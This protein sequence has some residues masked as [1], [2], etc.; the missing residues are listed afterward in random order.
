MASRTLA[1]RSVFWR[2]SDISRFIPAWTVSSGEPAAL[3]LLSLI[4]GLGK[5]INLKTW[6]L[7]HVVVTSL[8]GHPESG[9]EW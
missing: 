1:S 8:I 5:M 9:L 2:R 7:P 6:A 3:R 4:H